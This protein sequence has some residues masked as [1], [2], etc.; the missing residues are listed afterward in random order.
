M[1]KFIKQPHTITTNRPKQQTLINTATKQTN[2]TKTAN[3]PLKKTHAQ[4]QQNKTKQT[5][6]QQQ[7]EL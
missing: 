1:N 7:T 3:I 5:Q 4:T 2:T 6:L